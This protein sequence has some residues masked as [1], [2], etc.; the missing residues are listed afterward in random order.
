VVSIS[1]MSIGF[2]EFPDLRRARP[3][4]RA[5]RDSIARVGAIDRPPCDSDMPRGEEAVPR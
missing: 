3:L 2:T 4:S 1:A 5:C